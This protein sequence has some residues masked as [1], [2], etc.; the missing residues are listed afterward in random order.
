MADI[1]KI[2]L[3]NGTSYDFKDAM[4]RSGLAGKAAA[5]HTHTKSQITDF[6]TI[7]T[8]TSQLTNDSGFK[9]TD[10]NTTYSLSKSGSTI[11]LTGSDGSKT[12]VTDSNTT[13]ST[14]TGATS[15]AAG[16]TGLVP[17]PATGAANRYLRSDGTWQVPPDNNTIYGVVSKTA[18]GLVPKL[19]DETTATKYL[20][21]DGT[22]VVPPNTVYTHPTTSG[23]KHIPA[24]GSSGQILRWSADGTAVWGN[25]NNT[26]YNDAT[27]STH[28]LMSVSD[29]KALDVLKTPYATCATG[30]A[31]ADKVAA[32]ANFTLSVG[33]TIVVMFTDTAGTANPTS[34]NLRLNVNN[35]GARPI[36]YCRWGN[37]YFMTYTNGSSFY[38]N[39]VHIFTYDGT[40]WICMDWNADNN[41]T[42]S[43]ATTSANGLM[44]SSDKSKLDGIAAG[45]NK[46]TV[47]SAL[48]STSTNP[49]QNKV[50]NSALAGKASSSHTHSEYASKAKYEDTT[51]NVG[52]K[53]GTTV[54]PYSTAEGH[55]TTSSGNYSHAEGSHT[56]AS[57]HMSHAEGAS[58]TAS[59]NYSHAEGFMTTASGEYSHA[60]GRY[61]KALH[62]NEVAYGIY[63]ESND[64]TLFSI[65]DGTSDS[66]RH[67]AFE[68]TTT[69]GKLHD[70]DIATTE[71]ISNPNLLINPDFSINQYG[72]SGAFSDTGK[73]FVD[74]WRLVSG[75]VTVNTDGTI[76]LNGSICQPLENAAGANVTA[77]VS[78]GT[79]VYDNTTQTFTITGNGDVISWAKL[80][81]GSVATPFVSP[82][83]ILELIKCQRFYY[84]ARSTTSRFLTGYCM[85]SNMANVSIP[86]F[87]R[88]NPTVDYE[89]L[90][91]MCKDRTKSD[92]TGSMTYT[93]TSV[94]GY[95]CN[96]GI[97]LE[98]EVDTSSIRMS[99]GCAV[100]LQATVPGVYGGYF[101]LD[102]EIY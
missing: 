14:M 17:A 88:T 53:A 65:G 34:G 96:F 98:F 36:A 8:K 40:Y 58:T 85:S 61:T 54:G 45:A 102:A 76:T 87:M 60:G 48:S 24:G 16:K 81:I 47:D 82:D 56:T 64:D 100:T 92:D 27:T 83:P 35:T 25:D 2:T 50:I 91:V 77:S 84:R 3:P 52:R 22:W 15:S 71:N 33:A 21:Q 86:L 79:A 73:Y 63:N 80:E 31:T 19:P 62:M 49:V 32:L 20:R 18:N 23:N 11:T 13:Y 30:R 75:T 90:M 55:D 66:A 67:N 5:S 9:T 26:T 28:G 7:P 70:K 74:R 38:N 39:A 59:G 10:S 43:V 78:A 89:G 68:I 51:I 41:T 69:G 57:G 6:P 44:S 12:S 99:A 94:R 4:A 72:I 95:R 29:K 97:N 1:S 101:A 37:R 42:Y 46:T 93:I